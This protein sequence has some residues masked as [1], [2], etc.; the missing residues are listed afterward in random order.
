MHYVNPAAEQFFGSAAPPDRPAAERARARRQPAVRADRA[1][2]ATRRRGGRGRRHAG[3]AAHRQPLRRRFACRRSARAT[4]LVVLSLH[5]RSIAR[6]IDRQMSHRGAARSVTAMAAMLAHEVKNPLSGIRGAAQ[7]LESSVPRQRPRADPPDLR[8][9]RPH[10]ARW[11]TAWRC[12]PTAG[13]SSAAGQHPPGAGPCAQRRQN[14]FAQAC[15]SSRTTTRRCP[16]V[17]GNR[18]QLVQVFLNLVKNAAEAC[19]G[20]IASGEIALTT[21]YQHGV[22]LAVPGSRRA[23]TCRWSSRCA[24]TARGIPDEIR[25]HLFEPSSPPSRPA[26]GL[27]LALVA[28]IVG[29]HGG[30]DRVR[31]PARPHR[32]PRACCRCSDE[33]ARAASVDE[34]ARPSSSPTTTARSAPC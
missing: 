2:A 17:C 18:D 12:S 5:E 3:V 25:A 13:R 11:S 22:R 20:A 15:A 32:V 19:R 27:G 33:T 29:D 30:A 26:P 8:R 34:R 4:A 23:C 28:K 14:G 31:Q 1:G 6:K 24:T 7:L 16:P 10:R 9:D 21:A